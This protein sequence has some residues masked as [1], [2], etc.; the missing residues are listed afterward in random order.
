MAG[1]QSAEHMP[2][3]AEN[4]EQFLP[5]LMA[6]KDFPVLVSGVLILECGCFGVSCDRRF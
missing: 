4:S 6:N 2:G 3:F 1:E 5:E